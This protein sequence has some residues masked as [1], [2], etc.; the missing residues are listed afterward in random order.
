MS[1]ISDAYGE[2]K[3]SS[4]TYQSI[5]AI[6]VTRFIKMSR[7]EYEQGEESFWW[8][9]MSDPGLDNEGYY[10][11]EKQWLKTHPQKPIDIQKA[12]RKLESAITGQKES[13]IQA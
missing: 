3:R 4:L 1:D 5:H 2:Y 8:E 13:G 9:E 12:M 10:P 6:C 11:G 7:E